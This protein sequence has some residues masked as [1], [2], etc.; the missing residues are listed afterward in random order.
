[1]N[2]RK[3]ILRASIL[4]EEIDELGSNGIRWKIRVFGVFHRF[5]GALKASQSINSLGAD[6]CLLVLQSLDQLLLHGLPEIVTRE[7]GERL[8]I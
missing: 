1:M 8:R 6:G 7:P 2:E 3:A 5:L 4:L